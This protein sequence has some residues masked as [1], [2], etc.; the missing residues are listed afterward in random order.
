VWLR[1]TA[2]AALSQPTAALALIDS[3]L[4]LPV[5]TAIDIGLAPYTDGRAQYTAT[6]AWVATWISREL[7]VHGDSIAARQAAMRAVSWYRNRPAAERA[8]PEERFT[9]SGSLEMLGAY[10]DAEQIVRGLAAED[11]TNVDFRGQ[12]AGLAAERGDTALADSLDRWLA[13]QSVARVTWTASIYRARVAALLGRRDQAVARVR[14]A[15][16]EGAW[17]G[18]FHQEPAIMSLRSRPDF[19]AMLAPRN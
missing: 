11:S 9:A 2:L 18:W 12:L 17:P 5:E 1:G 8:T 10:A 19:V 15:L 4:A 6:P 14:E 13:A 7:A 16:D 3:S